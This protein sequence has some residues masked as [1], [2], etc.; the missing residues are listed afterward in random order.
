MTRKIRKKNGSTDTRKSGRKLI[1]VNRLQIC[2]TK[3]PKKTKASHLKP[4]RIVKYLD[5]KCLRNNKRDLNKEN[6]SIEEEVPRHEEEAYLDESFRVKRS[7]TKKA[8]KD[9]LSNNK[10]DLNT[11]N[12]SIEEELP[13]REDEAYFDEPFR[14]KR[15]RT[16]K[17]RKNCSI[18]NKCDLNTE[19]SSI[20]EELPCREDEACFDE[21]FRVKIRS[22][23]A[24]IS[25][26]I[27]TMEINIFHNWSC[28]APEP[29]DVFGMLEGAEKLSSF[30]EEKF[31][32]LENNE[33][34]QLEAE[35]IKYAYCR[36]KIIIYII[37]NILGRLGEID[38]DLNYEKI[39]I[40]EVNK[41]LHLIKRFGLKLPM[42]CSVLKSEKNKLSFSDFAVLIKSDLDLF[43]LKQTDKVK[44]I[45][46][47]T[48]GEICKIN[49]PISY[50]EEESLKSYETQF[51]REMSNV[52]ATPQI[53]ECEALSI[54]EKQTKR[55]LRA[56]ESSTSSKIL[57]IR[58]N[59]DE[60]SSLSRENA[61]FP[62]TS[63]FNTIASDNHVE[64]KKR[65][66]NKKKKATTSFP[67][68]ESMDI[69]NNPVESS[70]S[71]DITSAPE[72][73]LLISAT[74]DGHLEKK[75][76]PDN[77]KHG[78]ILISD[79]ELP[80]I[81]ENKTSGERGQSKQCL[82]IAKNESEVL[83]SQCPSILEDNSPKDTEYKLLEHCENNVTEF[84]ENNRS[85]E[86]KHD[87]SNDHGN[88]IPE[89]C[90]KDISKY[91]ENNLLE[92][93]K[94]NVFDYSG[95]NLCEDTKHQ[96]RIKDT[97]ANESGK[98][99][100]LPYGEIEK[101]IE[102][103]NEPTSVCMFSEVS[104][105]FNDDVMNEEIVFGGEVT[106]SSNEIFKQELEHLEN[107]ITTDPN[108]T[109]DNQVSA[110]QLFTNNSKCNENIITTDPNDTCDDQASANQLV[111][112]N[113]KC[114]ENI[115]IA[116]PNKTCD[117]QVSANQLFTNNSKCNE[118]IITADPNETCDNQVS[119]NQL[120]TNNSKCNATISTSPA[121]RSNNK[122][123]PGKSLL[124]C[125]NNSFSGTSLLIP[126]NLDNKV[127]KKK[128]PYNKKPK[129]D[130]VY[131][132]EA[133]V[134]V[135][136]MKKRKEKVK[137]IKLT[138]SSLPVLSLGSEQEVKGKVV[139]NTSQVPDV[140]DIEDPAKRIN[141][142][143]CNKLDAKRSMNFKTYKKSEITIPVTK[144]IKNYFTMD[145]KS[146]NNQEK[147]INIT[148]DF[149]KKDQGSKCLNNEL[150]NKRNKVDIEV[151]AFDCGSSGSGIEVP[152]ENLEEVVKNG[153]TSH[154]MNESFSVDALEK[155]VKVID[156]PSY[157]GNNLK[158]KLSGII[159]QSK[160]SHI[161]VLHSK[162]NL[163]TNDHNYIKL[164][165]INSEYN[166]NPDYDS[167]AGFCNEILD[168]TNSQINNTGCN[169]NLNNKNINDS[170]NNITENKSSYC[171]N[172]CKAD[173]S[174][175]NSI[176]VNSN[177][178]ETKTEELMNTEQFLQNSIDINY[179]QNLIPANVSENDLNSISLAKITKC[180]H[181]KGNKVTNVK[182]LDLDFSDL[183]WT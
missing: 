61:D 128:R 135:Q 68:N 181:F 53:N 42:D 157:E 112:N 147:F 11:E 101:I 73:S 145:L 26:Y 12:S 70:L 31:Y 146:L 99:M 150:L 161:N 20:E 72:I 24:N 183:C 46:K 167:K 95:N 43:S 96:E 177:A 159:N 139:I 142:N 64:K 156:D 109:C 173:P 75:K 60:T 50:L 1:T 106:V 66:Y 27:A 44:G 108:D 74:S 105:P 121:K 102:V 124:R 117:N 10:C 154:Y 35:N 13:C 152:I 84:S 9:Y 28:I 65:R 115:I 166:S 39:V 180:Q 138:N 2:H 77:K 82:Y 170:N 118:N 151:N 17:A 51:S 30:L 41:H 55:K 164:R 120:F 63:L 172:P 134:E 14:V 18:N 91:P 179:S 37:K 114:N 122:K 125:K 22:L 136:N 7:R 97:N 141:S 93:Y 5:K 86:R 103:K 178:V 81:Q 76:G 107:I 162:D 54:Q 85:E 127:E 176:E 67:Y 45:L 80:N 148:E 90:K 56:T 23:I 155:I 160:V 71:N 6:S 94:N 132:M 25:S 119:A 130:V 58:N 175:I 40:I 163:V 52:E 69:G 8:K 36:S 153:E 100:I 111:T 169:F 140:V 34:M 38:D 165:A 104:V 48:A 88:I 98:D 59:H 171:S 143:S 47:K 129:V 83:A 78:D 79:C 57:N 110:N 4:T 116:D 144:T 29:Q 32:A 49:F 62:E 168:Q 87:V 149:L 126:T 131:G 92:D 89:D 33:T 15:S 113:S 137:N 158:K 182:S 174:D 19:N 21:P 3:R 16:L 133:D 123:K